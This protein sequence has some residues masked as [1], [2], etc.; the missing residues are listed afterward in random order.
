MSVDRA[1]RW[2]LILVLGALGVTGS[3]GTG[4]AA[5]QFEDLVL[6]AVQDSAPPDSTPASPPP[7][8]PRPRV[9]TTPT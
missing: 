8:R 3:A 5:G 6:A 2:I 4:E 9:S 1:G 7:R